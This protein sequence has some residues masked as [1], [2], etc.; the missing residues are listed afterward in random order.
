LVKISQSPQVLVLRY[1]TSDMQVEIRSEAA[2]IFYMP[3]PSFA[4]NCV[5]AAGV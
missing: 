4:Y 2:I 1:S 5:R 3:D